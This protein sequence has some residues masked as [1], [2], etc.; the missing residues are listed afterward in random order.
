[1]KIFK[2]IKKI[3][4]IFILLTYS[5]HV[6]A[7]FDS[8]KKKE[9]SYLEF[10]L[11]KLENKLINRSKVLGSEYFPTR[12]QYSSVGVEVNYDNKNEKILIGVYAVMD[13]ARYSKKKYKQKVSDCNIIRN[14]IFYKKKGYK[15]FTQKR[16]FSLS[17]DNMEKIFKEAFLNNLTL[18]EKEIEF[19]LNN[20]FVTV[21]IY[22][23][24]NKT[25]LTCNGKANDFELR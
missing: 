23:P 19:L 11:L 21:S 20:M 12:V 15:F 25:E 18:N 7:S 10:L 8:F 3:L 5:S 17:K 13:K 16:D 2:F 22:H 24:V 9:T 14:L 1:M 6:I 4:V